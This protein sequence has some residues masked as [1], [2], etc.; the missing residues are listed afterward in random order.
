[1][2]AGKAGTTAVMRAQGARLW[3]WSG[4]A[5][6]YSFIIEL[7]EPADVCNVKSAQGV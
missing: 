1:M 7:N 6:D 4:Q 5:T 2:F 3:P